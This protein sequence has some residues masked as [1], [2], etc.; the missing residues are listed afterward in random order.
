MKVDA[1]YF[2][3]LAASFWVSGLMVGLAVHGLF[4]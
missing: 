4:S 1:K 3:P 2:W